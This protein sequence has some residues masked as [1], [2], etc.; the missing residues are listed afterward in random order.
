MSWTIHQHITIN[1]MR[2]DTISNS[3]VL[4]VGSAGSIRSL[5]QL[6]N[7]GG[8]TSPAPQLGSENPLSFVPLP[9]PS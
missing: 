9:N 8:F 1:C 3:S 6:Y 7:T 4:Q 5:S 2:I